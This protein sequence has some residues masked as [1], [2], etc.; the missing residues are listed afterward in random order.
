MALQIVKWPN[1]DVSSPWP[2]TF[3]ADL[4]KYTI[5]ALV[6]YLVSKINSDVTA[7]VTKAPTVKATLTN[8]PKSVHS[9]AL[10]MPRHQVLFVG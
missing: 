7:K 4:N 10:L 8:F 5:H 9:T 6:A 3:G 1:P 2:E